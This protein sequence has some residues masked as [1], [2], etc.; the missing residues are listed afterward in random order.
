MLLR[1]A[2][3]YMNTKCSGFLSS[4]RVQHQFVVVWPVALDDFLQSCQLDGM[5]HFLVKSG[6]ACQRKF[7]HHFY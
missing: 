7:P 5:W 4:S 1:C 3:K 2:L 6:N